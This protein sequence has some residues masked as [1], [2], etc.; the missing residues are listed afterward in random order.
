MKF[1]VKMLPYEIQLERGSFDLMVP[2][3]LFDSFLVIQLQRA[4]HIIMIVLQMQIKFGQPRCF[5]D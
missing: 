1:M 5:K 4:K 2:R 3:L